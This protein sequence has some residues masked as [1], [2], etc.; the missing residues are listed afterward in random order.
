MK[1]LIKKGFLMGL[2]LLLLFTT[3]CART[4]I[5]NTHKAKIMIIVKAMDNDFWKTVILGC[6]SARKEFDVD[7]EVSYPK[8]EKDV[9]GQIKL[10]NL[11]ISKKAD[12]IVLAACDYER[13]VPV[14]EKA[15]KAGIPVIVIDSAVNS[16][17]VSSF[18]ATD[19]EQT[20][21]V[22][23][24]ELVELAGPKC[25]VVI[26]N[27][28]KG[29]ATGDQREEGLMEVINKHPGIKVLDK[30]Y[31]FSDVGIA[32]AQT[33]VVMKEY[34]N[35]DVI[36]ALNA[37]TTNGVCKAIKEMKLGGK[38]K[39]IGFDSTHEE[40][41]AIEEDVMQAAIVQNPYSMGYLGIKNALEVL[42]KKD[43]QKYVDTG[44]K[45]IDKSNMYTPENQKLLFPFVN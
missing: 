5:S 23:G 25:N 37:P 10:V 4:D 2:V 17:K 18:I 31:S 42:E 34:L 24:N 1:Y 22:V 40:I 36:I 11:A 29:A 16:P 26:M 28:V 13:L 45:V 12:A 43:V 30:E 41:D 20:G 9:K 21:G 33:K 39:V 32:R 15:I 3:S 44:S 6:E 7:M 38:V 14:T 35:V 27:F 8:N 19:N